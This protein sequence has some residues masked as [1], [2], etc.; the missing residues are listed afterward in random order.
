M[1]IG[2]ILTVLSLYVP[3]LG[4]QWL[5]DQPWVCREGE[6]AS[7]NPSIALRSSARV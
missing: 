2:D 1:I 5:Y 3:R 7:R 6:D 4:C